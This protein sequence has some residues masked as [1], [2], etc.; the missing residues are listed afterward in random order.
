METADDT[1]RSDW[2]MSA[3]GG[4]CYV[5]N[6]ASSSIDIRDIAAALSRL[7]RFGGHLRDDVDH[8]S[9]AQHSVL[10]S[11]VCRP[12]N[13]L[14]GLLHDAT[15]AYLQ[16]LIQPLKR[17]L[18]TY[19]ELERIWAREIGERFGLGPRLVD[20]P[21]DVKEADKILLATE[22]RDLA[23]NVPKRAAW[24]KRCGAKPLLSTIEP[25]SAWGARRA[26]IA[27][28]QILTGRESHANESP[29]DQA[30][31]GDGS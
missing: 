2:F 15:E 31:P 29:A 30:R 21:P 9:V 4:L 10:V 24:L 7:C 14:V 6:P 17:S 1:E 16:D 8:Y 19:K 3:T 5:H 12:E 25:L 18:P 23:E 13:A 26:F 28:F 27:R 22:M 11:R 20:L